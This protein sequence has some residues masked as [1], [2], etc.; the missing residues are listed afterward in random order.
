M[1][2]ISP[3]TSE[4]PRNS[5]DPGA[6]LIDTLR[7]IPDEWLHP[8][9]FLLD[10]LADPVIAC[11]LDF[12]IRSW[13]KKA[14]ELYGAKEEE[15]IGRPVTEVLFHEFLGDT[16]E[17]VWRK[18]RETGKWKGEV[19]QVGKDGKKLFMEI[20]SSCVKNQKGQTIGYVSICRDIT[21]ILRVKEDLLAEQL[22]FRDLI[23]NVPGVVYQW[24]ENYDG[25]FGFTYVSPK[26]EE[27]FGV[28]QEDIYKHPDLI[29]PDDKKR[30][31]E[32]ID[33]ANR[34]EKPWEFEG[35]L[36]YPDG[37][38]KWWRGSSVMSM[39]TEKGRIYNGIMI[40]ITARK[41]QETMLEKEE[42]EKKRE[43]I[44]AIMDAQE[45]ERR[46]ISAELH[47][48][49]NQI[50]TTCMLF[51][52]IAR[53]NPADARFIDGCYTNIQNVIGEIRNISHNLT[54]YTLKDL[55]LAAAIRDIVEKINQSGKLLIILVSFQNLE[56]EKISPDIKLALFR[57]IQEKISNV[58]KHSQATE[59]K[60]SLDLYDNLVYLKLTDNGRGF[61]EAAIKKGLGL[62]NIQNRVEYYKGNMKLVTAP[63]KGCELSVQLPC[64]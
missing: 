15:V 59:L 41:N 52:E 30:L 19:L 26:I 22:R 48:N 35:R 58:L 38:I 57:I 25:S 1:S 60:I 44:K 27:Y 28:R 6:E 64:S 9:S 4:I 29:H 32:S 5:G 42:V 56:E 2:L 53:N 51:L 37:S 47:D 33:E 63:G 20:S 16:R 36:L 50:L 54:P 14:E 7:E 34:T 24:E 40:D 31:R 3:F 43:I 45:K 17:L 39:K 12:N 11:D 21:E 18:L 46:E 55:G 62:N 8:A 49:V 13:N 61:D 23:Q 10:N